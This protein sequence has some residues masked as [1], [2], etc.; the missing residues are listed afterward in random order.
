M[1][2]SQYGT[3]P[4]RSTGLVCAYCFMGAMTFFLHCKPMQAHWDR[5][6]EDAKC[7]PISLFVTFALVNTCRSRLPACRFPIY[8]QTI[9]FNIFTDVLFATIPIPIVWKLQMK[10]RVR[11]YLIGVFSLGYMY[12]STL[13]NLNPLLLQSL[14]YPDNKQTAQLAWAW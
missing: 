3:M 1:G 7:Y 6:I 8:S 11:L 4:I 2:D 14:N 9:A 13:L 12:A 5:R 10:A